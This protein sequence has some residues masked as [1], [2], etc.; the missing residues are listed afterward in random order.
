MSA[1][2]TLDKT[3]EIIS[4][5]VV[6]LFAYL[7]HSTPQVILFSIIGPKHGVRRMEMEEKLIRTRYMSH[8]H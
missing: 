7:R 4:P 2:W 5:C 3:G 6:L 1:H 8:N